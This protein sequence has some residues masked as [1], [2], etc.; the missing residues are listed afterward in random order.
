MKIV[1]F[2]AT[3]IVGRA[4]TEAALAA[5]NEVT[6]L[7]R[8]ASKVKERDDRLHVIEGRVDDL[9]TLCRIIRGQDAVIQSLGIGGRGDGRPTTFVSDTN[10]LIMQAM[11][12]TGVRRLI[13]VSAIGAGD[14]RTYLPWIYRKFI[15]PV[16]QKWFV[17]IIDDKNRME[18]EIRDS[19]LDWTIVR[20]T[21]VKNS[22]AKGTVVASLDG[23]GL[24]FTVAAADMGRFVAAQA[25]SDEF[26]HKT[27]TISG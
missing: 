16:F 5:G 2:G 15:L 9:P 24:K 22:P 27:P 18:P 19:G 6:V 8:D 13:A 17:P 4:I 14:S 12:E 10:R 1:I 21:T 25:A 7:T 11:K 26:L 23:R 20:L 3:G